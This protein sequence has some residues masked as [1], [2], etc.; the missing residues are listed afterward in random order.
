MVK[1]C[2]TIYHRTLIFVYDC[3]RVNRIVLIVMESGLPFVAYSERAK[4]GQKEQENQQAQSP[5]QTAHIAAPWSEGPS[6]VVDYSAAATPLH[7]A[8][9]AIVSLP[10]ITSITYCHFIPEPPFSNR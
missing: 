4:Q 6:N 1:F 2:A 8:L 5:T 7:R 10:H 9:Q 3:L